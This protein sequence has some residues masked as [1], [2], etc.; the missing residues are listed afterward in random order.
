V[1]PRGTFVARV[2]RNPSAL[3]QRINELAQ[4]AGASVRAINSAFPDSGQYGIGSETVV[5]VKAPRVLI[6]AGEGIDQTAFGAVWF[7]F[8]H[9]LGVPVTPVNMRSLSWMDLYDYNVLI[10]PSGSPGTLSRELGEEG[11]RHLKQWVRSGAA[12]IAMSDAA[13]LLSRKELEMSSLKTIGSDTGSKAAKDSLAKDTTLA[14]SARP[15]PPLVSPS[16]SGGGQPEFIPGAIFRATLDRTHWLTYGYE[17]DQ[18]PVLLENSRM[19][20]PSEK[21]ANPVVFVGQDLTLG[22]FTWPNNTER[23]LRRSTWAAVESFGDGRVVVFAENPVYRGFWRGTAKLLTN[24]VLF[25]P[26]R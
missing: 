18:L 25:G 2:Q 1:Y 3:H 17:R 5:G 4:E 9:E 20:K 16:A 13:D 23:F 12:V 21:G 19:I 15:G 10:I 8:D 14:P 26:N 7:Y 11:A 22:G 6:A 24:A